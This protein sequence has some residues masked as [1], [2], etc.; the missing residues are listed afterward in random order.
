MLATPAALMAQ[1]PPPTAIPQSPE[2]ELKAANEQNR[3]NADQFAK[4]AV[5]MFVEPAVHFKA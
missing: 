3:R 2:D 5:P 4:I 1:A